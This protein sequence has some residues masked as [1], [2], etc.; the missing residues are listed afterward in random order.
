MGFGSRFVLQLALQ[1]KEVFALD[2]ESENRDR[3]VEA[4]RVPTLMEEG[5]IAYNQ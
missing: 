3:V 5:G 2:S 1:L 4:V